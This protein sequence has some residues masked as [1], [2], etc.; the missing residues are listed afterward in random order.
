MTARQGGAGE[1]SGAVKKWFP[2]W[3]P[4]PE[5]ALRLFCFP[6]AGGSA[7]ALH[8]WA[9]LGPT[10]E[11]LAVQYPG[12]ET[13]FHE[14]PARRVTELVEALGPAMLPLLDRP[15]AFFGYSL[16]TAISL[17]LAYWLRQA[18][19]PAPRGVMMAAGVPLKLREPRSTY[20]LPDP[21]L[22][23][24][25][26]EYG[27]TPPEVL[28]HKELMEMLLPTV[29]A[30]FEMLETFTAPDEAPLSVP[31]AVWGGTEDQ[32]PSP[33]EL[34]AWRDYTSRDFSLQLI[35]GGHFFLFSAADAL[36]E[37]MER[38][39]IRWSSKGT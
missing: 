6:F 16:G 9:D 13:R 32:R 7:S 15:F 4:R 34:E 12:R 19:A 37:A 29:R 31:L 20:T 38:T 27:A 22:I 36:R 1:A 24:E 11:V 8:R 25:L 10:V 3:K 30:D 17:Q 28:A 14:P 35:P 21:D 18:G 26:R 39:L 23:A 33:Q 2:Y 5:A